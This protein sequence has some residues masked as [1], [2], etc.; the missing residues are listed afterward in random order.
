M[1]RINPLHARIKPVLWKSWLHTIESVLGRENP[2]LSSLSLIFYSCDGRCFLNE[3]RSLNTFRTKSACLAVN[4][5]GAF[6]AV[7]NQ[8]RW[9]LVQSHEILREFPSSQLT[10]FIWSL[11]TNE[12]WGTPQRTYELDRNVWTMHLIRLELRSIFLSSALHF[13]HKTNELKSKAPHIRFAS[14]FSLSCNVSRLHIGFFSSHR[15]IFICVCDNDITTLFKMKNFM[16]IAYFLCHSIVFLVY[17][18]RP[19][20]FFGSHSTN[21]DGSVCVLSIRIE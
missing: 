9:T 14:F 21:G 7:Q 19:R 17:F 13:A 18:A 11:L 2:S 6:G 15:K 1:T 16:R 20:L 10:R 3:R 5:C 8:F 12:T 4:V